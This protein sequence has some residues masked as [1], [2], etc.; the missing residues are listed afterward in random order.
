L[1]LLFGL[2]ENKRQILNFILYMKQ[3]LKFFFAEQQKNEKNCYLFASAPIPKGS[4]F[5][6]RKGSASLPSPCLSKGES[7]ADPL[8][9]SPQRGA[10][11]IPLLP[12]GERERERERGARAEGE[13]RPKE[14][15]CFYF[16]AER[17]KTA[18]LFLFLLN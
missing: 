16:A 15:E 9:P 8:L 14:M 1:N 6:K 4:S 18:F 10:G 17:K 11:E 13:S 3:K 7:E 5:R 12:F 2:F